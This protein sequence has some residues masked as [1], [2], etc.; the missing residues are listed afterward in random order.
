MNR[1]DKAAHQGVD[2]TKRESLRSLG[3]LGAALAAGVTA[4]PAVLA[5]QPVNV[6]PDGM[7]KLTPVGLQG[8]FYLNL[9][10]VRADIAEGRPG[11]PLDLKFTLIDS[12]TC[13]P[14]AN[15]VI[16]L[17][18]CDAGGNYSGY[19]YISPDVAGYT[20]VPLGQMPLEAPQLP[21][22]NGETFCRGAQVTNAAGQVRFRTIYPSWYVTRTVHVHLKV[23]LQQPTTGQTAVF[24]TQMY[25][26]D[27]IS[28]A[29]LARPEYTNRTVAR[30]TF[31]DTD[32]HFVAMQGSRDIL[33][34]RRTPTG[35]EGSHHLGVS[36]T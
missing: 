28:A 12:T 17:W 21:A 26:D 1:Q 36:L 15:A 7:C 25:F 4:G 3:K 19:P 23:F 24:T 9:N 34:L 29:V 8:P 6:P 10:K 14:Y 31:N 13:R 32:R 5:A 2:G 18:H 11:V 20:P 35:Y 16:D 27:A 22:A 33:R 30:D